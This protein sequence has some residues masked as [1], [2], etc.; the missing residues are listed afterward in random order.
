MSTYEETHMR[1]NKFTHGMIE[2]LIFINKTLN[3]EIYP[4]TPKL[5]K[6]LEVSIATI[7]RDIEFLRDRLNAPIEYNYERKGYYYSEKYHL[8][9][10]L[11]NY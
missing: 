6:Q 10:Q 8:Y 3:A 5:A 9:E 7:S 4:N 1:E 11:E 2:R